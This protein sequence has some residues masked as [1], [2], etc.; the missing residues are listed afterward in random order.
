MTKWRGPGDLPRSTEFR[1]VGSENVQG[2]T[3][4]EDEGLVN[5]AGSAVMTAIPWYDGRIVVREDT[6]EARPTGHRA[7]HNIKRCVIQHPRKSRQ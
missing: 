7:Y 6:K 1:C 4:A 2:K 3:L 5:Q